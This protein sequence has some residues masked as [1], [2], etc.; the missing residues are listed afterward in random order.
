M[1]K[2]DARRELQRLIDEA[3]TIAPSIVHLKGQSYGDVTDEGFNPQKA[4]RWEVEATSLLQGLASLGSQPFALLNGHYHEE[5]ARSANYHSRSIFIHKAVQ[6]LTTAVE[7]L[8]SAA[9]EIVLPHAQQ[10]ATVEGE[11][12]VPQHV[13][14]LWLLKH[15]PITLWLTAIGVLLAVFL[16]G[17]EVAGLQFVQEILGRVVRSP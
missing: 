12:T 17:I 6:C 9:S 11:P 8:E 2:V 15:V 4:Q 5:K 1:N 14:I 10:F 16:F 3:P 13:T 7:L